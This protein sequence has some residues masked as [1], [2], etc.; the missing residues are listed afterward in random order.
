MSAKIQQEFF[1]YLLLSSNGSTYVGATINLHRRLDQHNKFLKGGAKATTNCV[2]RGEIWIR[3]AHVK[4]FPTWQSALQFEW[5]WKQISRK[6]YKN[7]KEPA[8]KRRMQALK[9]LLS[10]E[11]STANAIPFNEWDIKPEVILEDE[12]ARNYYQND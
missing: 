7:N 11:K 2:E 1:V 5:R 6:I 9:K 8:I 3:A 4:N 12:E 10:L